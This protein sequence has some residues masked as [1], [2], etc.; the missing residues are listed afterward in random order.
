MLFDD[1]DDTEKGPFCKP[2][3]LLFYENIEKMPSFQVIEAY[4]SCL[5]EAQE[6]IQKAISILEATLKKGIER[7]NSIDK[8]SELQFVFSKISGSR[9]MVEKEIER[10]SQNRQA[11]DQLIAEYSNK[12]ILNVPLKEFMTAFDAEYKLKV[13]K[14]HIDTNELYSVEINALDINGCA[15]FDHLNKVMTGY[16]LKKLLKKQTL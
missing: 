3:G 9:G 8:P 1:M 14:K 16:L 6:K 12:G 13:E 2:F 11:I 10:L 15:G 4:L 5:I 7:L